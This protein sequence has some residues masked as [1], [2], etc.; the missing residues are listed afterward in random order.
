[1]VKIYF[2][3]EGGTVFRV[4]TLQRHC[5][6]SPLILRPIGNDISRMPTASRTRKSTVDH[7]LHS[8][9]L[10]RIR[11]NK[12]G[13]SSSLSQM[14]HHAHQHHHHQQQ[15]T[16]TEEKRHANPPRD[17]KFKGDAHIRLP[18]PQPQPHA[19]TTHTPDRTTPKTTNEH[20]M[21]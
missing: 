1:M 21:Q 4:G 12:H 20:G 3:S 2:R 5:N 10:D 8:T 6:S 9:S 15:H 7:Y 17:R 18:R 19:H 13:I 16:S 11:K 14:K